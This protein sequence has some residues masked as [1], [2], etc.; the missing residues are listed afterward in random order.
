RRVMAKSHKAQHWVPRCYLS[1]W[2]DPDCPHGYEPFVHV[3]SR[4]GSEQSRRAPENIFTETDLYT[5]QLPDG[6]RDLRLEH[7]LSELEKSFTNMRRDF[8]ERRRPLPPARYVKLMAF[9]AALHARTPMLRDHWM[10]FWKDALEM[11]ERVERDMRGRSIKEKKH[12]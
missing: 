12:A 6:R 5:I 7:G 1:A 2:T 9:V 3:F 10:G 8:L 4:D 11:M